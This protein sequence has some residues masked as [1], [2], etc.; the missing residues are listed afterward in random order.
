MSDADGPV[1]AVVLAAGQSRRMGQPKLLLPWGDSTV[2]GETLRQTQ[3]ARVRPIVVVT[4]HAAEAVAAIARV[5]G[6]EVRHNS[7]YATGEMLSSLQ[8]GLHT[9]PLETHGVLVILADQPLVTSATLNSLIDAFEQGLGTIIA[10]TYA[11]QTGNPVLI[12]RRWWAEL[13]ALPPGE[14]PRR[15]LLRHPAAVYHLPLDTPSILVDL[16]DRAAY[17]QWRP[18][19]AV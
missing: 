19:N 10:P 6:C 7:D 12:G 11:G 1:A 5:A 13:L 16:D 18:A 2:L 4:G 15:L 14:R 17:E 3:G 9:L 8:V